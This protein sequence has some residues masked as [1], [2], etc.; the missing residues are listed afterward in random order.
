M[1]T[2]TQSYRDWARGVRTEARRKIVAL[3][4]ERLARKRA[5]EPAV[6]A[7]DPPAAGPG[8]PLT[9]S[10]RTAAM[11]SPDAG[12]SVVGA[13]ELQTEVVKPA[14]D[15]TP[16]PRLVSGAVSDTLAATLHPAQAGPAAAE[17]LNAAPE[18]SVPQMAAAAESAGQADPQPET[19]QRDRPAQTGADMPDAE[20]DATDVAPSGR[21]ADGAVTSAQAGEA[22]PGAGCPVWD[23]ETLLASDLNALSGIGTG[24]L[25]LLHANGIT[26]LRELADA[27]AGTLSEQLGLVGRLI[28]LP[29]LI[30]NARSRQG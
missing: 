23:E 9:V 5:A 21:P 6:P 10:R 14:P 13:T 1:T 11:L 16:E 15:P 3:R 24:L 30:E 8:L 26:S 20:A 22:A 29:S 18:P 27:D 28:N 7:G 19:H 4:A 12:S 17:P 2:E 25:W